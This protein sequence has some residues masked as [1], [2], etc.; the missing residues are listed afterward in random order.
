MSDDVNLYRT[1]GEVLRH[2]RDYL[3]ARL[4][5]EKA[6]L[7]RYEALAKDVLAEMDA[8]LDSVRADV[9]STGALLAEFKAAIKAVG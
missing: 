2:E 4:K 9:R 8:L 7:A 6:E 5:D 1:P 3:K